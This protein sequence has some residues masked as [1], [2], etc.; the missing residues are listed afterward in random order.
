MREWSR[1]TSISNLILL[2]FL[3]A[4]ALPQAGFAAQSSNPSPGTPGDAVEEELE[5]ELEVLH[6]DRIDGSRY[7]YFLHSGGERIELNFTHA[8]TDLPTGS[9]VRVRGTRSLQT[10]ALDGTGTTLQA[11]SVALPNT[12]GAQKT[13]VILVNFQ[14]NPV[15]PYTVDYAKSTVF[16]TVSNYFYENSNH[17]TSLTGNIVGWY[18]VAL[19]T[20]DCT[21]TAIASAA[22]QA[23]AAN[24]IDLTL[25][26]HFVYAFPQNV[27]FF[28]G[29]GTIGGNPSESWI[30]GTFDLRVV[31]HEMGHNLGLYHSHSLDCGS[32]TLGSSCVLQA[33]GDVADI[34]GGDGPGHFN[35]F[36]K[37]RLGWLD[38]GVSPPI[39]TADVDG[40]YGL[41]PYETFDTDPKAIK[42]LKSV[43]ATTGAKTWYYVEYRQ[44][45]GFDNILSS[46]S[47]NIT[48]GVVVHLGSESNSDS[49]ELL[50]MTAG[51]AGGFDDPALTVGNSYYDP[52]A[53]VTI[54]PLSLNT[55]GASVSVTFDGAT[56]PPPPA[57]CVQ[58]NPT[59]A[60]SPSTMSLA[61]GATASYTVTVTN[62]D[63]SS[64]S[65]ASFS[66]S[67]SFPTGWTASLASPYLT[68]APGASASTTLQI[69]VATSAG[70]VTYTVGVGATNLSNT[71]YFGAGTATVTVL[72]ISIALTV[73]TDKL[74]YSRN[75]TVTV[76]AALVSGGT[77]VANAT[78]NFT[79]KKTDGSSVAGSAT[80]GSNGSAVYKYR[81]KSKDPKGNY[82]AL[83]KTS[84]SGTAASNS[85]SFLVQ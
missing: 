22:Q 43:D 60:L 8:P 70:A 56:T 75:Q 11:L 79:I 44:P 18:T 84:V 81:L 33:Y 6:E 42:I 74:S 82:S 64:C 23:A 32:V 62:N 4:L 85:T 16:T 15:Q 68:M 69:T 28:S 39:T 14:D 1:T 50:D 41:A 76:T 65:I 25:Y 63:S 53:G 73:S 29:M 71:A 83:G 20:S 45:I 13:L 35:A 49:S 27:C 9:H 5:G 2:F 24:G 3:F 19:S 80:T 10:L 30:N 46:L 77:P 21:T 40:V 72:P 17:Q 51:S 78:V 58:A 48:N 61:P 34:M 57:P 52:D 54:A 7:H 38:Y 67:K 47:S 55:T 31:G 66:L 37:E 26:N 36:Q 59:V 12:F